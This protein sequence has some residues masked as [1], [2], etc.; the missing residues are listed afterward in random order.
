MSADYKPVFIVEKHYSCRFRGLKFI[1][2]IPERTNMPFIKRHP[3]IEA[4]SGKRL[5][6][7]ELIGYETW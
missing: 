1:N 5:T 2:I 7:K 4:V 3:V 6:Y